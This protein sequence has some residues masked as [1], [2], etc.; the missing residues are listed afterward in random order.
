MIAMIGPIIELIAKVLGWW[1][2]NT[3][4]T[5]EQ[6]RDYIAFLEIMDRYGIASVKMR[7]DAV[8]QIDEIKE[9]WD[10]ENEGK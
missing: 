1:I 3:A 6:R 7:L 8:K 9:I 5:E 10:K 4:K 2:G